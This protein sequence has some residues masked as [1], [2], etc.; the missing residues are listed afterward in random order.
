M[1]SKLHGAIHRDWGLHYKRQNEL[2]KAIKSFQDS[3]QS[4]TELFRSYLENS[5]CQLQINQPAEAL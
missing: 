2:R 4:N 1:P 5:I 3:V